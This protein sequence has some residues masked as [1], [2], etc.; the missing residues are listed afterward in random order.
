M[1]I[2]SIINAVSYEDGWAKLA[3]MASYIKKT[4]PK[5]DTRTY[6]YEKIGQ[7][8][9]NLDYLKIEEH[10]FYKGSNSKHI[11]VAVEG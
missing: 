4:N 10:P 9:K 3:T 1:S 5:F 2:A 11:L 6:G 8:V 7:L